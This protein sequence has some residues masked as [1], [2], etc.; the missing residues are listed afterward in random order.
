[1]GDQLS[2]GLYSWME[3]A[4]LAVSGSKVSLVNKALAADYEAHDSRFAILHGSREDGKADGHLPVHD[5]TLRAT[6]CIIAL[7]SKD[8]QCIPVDGR[9]AGLATAT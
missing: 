8:A 4:V 3:A 2:P 6:R 1:M 9:R 7:T 5:V